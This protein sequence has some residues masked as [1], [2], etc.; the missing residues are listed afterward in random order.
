MLLGETYQLSMKKFRMQK[1]ISLFLAKRATKRKCPS[2]VTVPVNAKIKKF[3]V[4]RPQNDVRCDA[5][6]H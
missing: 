2:A 1:A 4:K 6:A 5:T 3:S